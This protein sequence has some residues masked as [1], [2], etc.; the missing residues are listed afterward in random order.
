V[1]KAVWQRYTPTLELPWLLE[2]FRQMLNDCIRIGLETNATSLKTLSLKAYK[3]LKGY[4]VPSCYK[5]C[6]ISR[7]TGILRNYRRAKRKGEDVKEPYARRLQLVTCYGIKIKDGILHMPFKSR[8]PIQIPL[9]QHTQQVLSEPDLAVRSV[10]LTADR[11]VIAYAK[12]VAEIQPKGLIGIDRNLD[13]LTLAKSSGRVERFNLTK[14]TAIKSNYR[15]I[16]SRFTRNDVRVRR[17]IFGKYGV[18]QRSKVQHILHNVSNHIVEDAKARQLGI[19][20]ENLKGIRKL[21]R[22]GNWQGHS[23]R[24]RMNSWSFYELQRQIDYKAHWE[25]LAV[26]YVDARGTSAR[27]SMCGTKTVP[28]EHRL[29]YCP[30]CRISFDRDVCA[31]KNVLARAPRF[32]ADARLIEAVVAESQIERNPQSREPRD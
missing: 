6:A 27:C 32:R 24:A 11:L 18:K 7:A 29:L 13:N 19:V 23:Y 8:Q 5:L 12:E 10:T 14:V 3:Q 26:I 4:K 2:Q 22:K 28:N 25:G 21:Y 1:V 30:N 9:N 20:M 16:K 17:R 15:A 31:A